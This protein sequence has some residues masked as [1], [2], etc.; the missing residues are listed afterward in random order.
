MPG[1]FVG[2]L[3]FGSCVLTVVLIYGI[4]EAAKAE[5]N[6][7]RIFIERMRQLCKPLQ[8]KKRLSEEIET[9]KRMPLVTTER[10][11]K[12]KKQCE[13]KEIRLKDT[14]K[15]MKSKNYKK[16]FKAEY[17]QLKIRY[18]KLE[19]TIARYDCGIL[20]FELTC[21]IDMLREQLKAMG[22]YMDILKLRAEKENIKLEWSRDHKN[23]INE[24]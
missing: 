3:L 20:D 6:A 17:W 11:I 14:A 1:M 7:R 15:L 13:I 8:E 10:M 18:E 23:G 16:R 4:C 5:S 12:M 21:P 24:E 19:T 22:G 2:I 9:L